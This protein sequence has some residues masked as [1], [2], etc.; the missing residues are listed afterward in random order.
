MRSPSD[1]FDD[2]PW[3]MLSG[4][5]IQYRRMSSGWPGPYSSSANCGRRNCLPVPPVPW[6]TI[7]ALSISPG[8]I[9]MRLPERG[10][11][12][13]S[14]GRLSPMRK[15]KSLRTTSPSL[16]R[17]ALRRCWRPAPRRP[18]AE[19]G[20]QP[21]KS[22]E[23]HRHFPYGFAVAGAPGVTNA[24]EA[25][26]EARCWP[27]SAPTLRNHSRAPAECHTT[28]SSPGRISISASVKP[29]TKPDTGPLSGS[30]RSK[31][32]IEFLPGGQRALII[33]GRGIGGGR[34]RPRHRPRCDNEILQPAWRRH[35]PLRGS[36]A[37][38]EIRPGDRRG[39]RGRR[40][41]NCGAGA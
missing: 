35:D 12:H 21:V 40:R 20:Q 22:G 7:T 27:G 34:M 24:A 37:G 15:R 28:H 5:M 4:R 18:L 2:L 25:G 16:R 32:E 29:G 13:L 10:V 11:V 3:P 1:G 26:S 38:E 6:R 36:V 19:P 14:R 39:R 8:G 33:E 17:P 9:A 41:R 23:D 30:P 31:L